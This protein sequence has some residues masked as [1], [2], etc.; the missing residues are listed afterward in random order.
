MD[1]ETTRDDHNR[2]LVS[3]ANR[4]RRRPCKEHDF[5]FAQ[6][7]SAP[8]EKLVPWFEPGLNLYAVSPCTRCNAFMV[9]PIG[10][11]SKDVE[12]A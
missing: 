6:F 3:Q 12:A 8:F 5:R 1:P 2:D 4:P 11:D 7:S 10:R 9:S